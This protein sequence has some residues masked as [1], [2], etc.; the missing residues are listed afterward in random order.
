MTHRPR[1]KGLLLGALR[2]RFARA[3]PYWPAYSVG[4][5]DTTR[6]GQLAASVAIVAAMACSL[7]IA[8]P[9]SASAAMPRDG[10]APLVGARGE[11]VISG[12]YVVVLR[13]KPTGRAA[14]QPAAAVARARAQGIRVE[15]EYGHALAGFAAPLSAAQLT[16]VRA[17]PDVAYVA[18]DGTA[19]LDD[20]QLAVPTWGLDRIDQHAIPL[21][22]VYSSNATGAGV[23]AYVIDTGI[24]ATHTEFGGRVSGGVDFVGDGNGTNDCYGHGTHV[25]GTIGGATYGVAKA[26]SLVPVRVFDCFGSPTPFSTII[27]AVDWVTVNHT[28]PSVA[29]MSL[30]GG[31]FQPLDDAVTNSINSGVVYAVAAG[32]SR[33]D[34]CGSSPARTAAALTVGA[35]NREDSRDTDYSNFGSCVTLFAPGTAITSAWIGSDTDTAVET[36]TSMATP[37][38]TGAAALY[39]QGKPTTPAAVIKQWLI[40]AATHDVVSN[41]GA[42]SPNRLLYSCSVFGSSIAAA[43]NIDGRV[44]LFGSDSSDTVFDRKQATPG[45][46]SGSGW[47][48]LY[49]GLRSIATET[50]ASGRVVMFGLDSAGFIFY[51][52]QNT[53]GGSWPAWT[54]LDGA[55]TSIAVAKNADGRMEIYGANQAGWIYH[56]IQTTPGNWTGSTWSQFDG[57]LSQ[58][59]AETNT[60]GRVE[61]YGIN[62]DGWVFYR[63]QTTPGDWTGSSWVRYDGA[64]ASIAAA[65]NADGRMEIFGT[66]ADGFTYHRIQT[67]PGNWTGSTWSQFD[68][69]LSQV[70]AE[71][72]TDGRVEL[73][74]V[75]GA[76]GVTHRVQTTPGNWSRSS[77]SQFDGSLRP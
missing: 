66:N 32:N 20:K 29:N 35:T 22:S 13:S 71:T 30:S 4:R 62:R 57:Q 42:G 74:G 3:Q 18:A 39:L 58:V 53:P 23:T 11:S 75:S 76:G 47:N 55:L 38:V 50:D 70:A 49:T 68:G 2:A 33:A 10:L 12:R 26:V 64:L 34:A 37:H 73:Y 48:T 43:R 15:R 69:Q 5:R 9:A 72:N 25:A 7:V 59:A 63:Q 44:Q 51:R 40:D 60:D 24:R 45:D 16:A 77:Q 56:R 8:V 6:T 41:I 1:V 28:G 67:T 21:D 65:K 31:A 17:D 27:S 36:G 14:T 52:Q 19:Q 54:R 61:L 46:W